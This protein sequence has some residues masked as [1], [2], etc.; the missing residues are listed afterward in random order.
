MNPV[1]ASYQKCCT[2][3]VSLWLSCLI[4]VGLSARADE[5]DTLRQKW[6]DV[7]VG[8]GYNTAD[9]AV[10]SKLTSVSN[11]A[12]SSWSSM[13]K[14]GSR[15]YL[16]SDAASTTVSADL[17]T[18]YSRLRNMALAYATP[19]CTLQGNSALLADTLSGLDWMHT[20]RYNPTKAIYDNWWDFEIGSPLQIVDIATLLYNQ[21]S[22]SQMSNY[23]ASVEKFTPSATTQAPGGT[24]G[25]FTGAN[26]M[27]KIRVVAV[28]GAVM[29]SS[30]KLAA[31]RD[32]FSE[33]FVYATSGDGFYT[34]GS[35]LQHTIHPYTAGYGNSLLSNIAPVMNWLAGSTW[36]VTDPSQA[37]L[38]RWVFDSYEPIIYRGASLDYVRGRE[39]GRSGAS[40][41]ATGHAMLDSVLQ[42]AQ[43]APP[44]DAARMKS[45]VKEW[46]LS[47]TVRD[48]VGGRPLPTLKM[49][50]DLMS[51]TN[52]VRRGELIAHYT[53]PEM[54]RVMHLGSGY[55]FG[56]SLCSTRIANF[57][58]INGENLQGWFTGDGMTILYNS[59]LNQYGDNYWP[60]IDPY[61]LPGVT[62]DVTKSK[63]PHQ[64]A[65]IGP[66]AQGQSTLSPYNW[67]GGA[68]LGRYGAAGMQFKGVG[69]TLTGKKS[70]FMFDD[71]IVCLGSGI[72]STDSRQ[73]ET[74][75][76]NRKLSSS[77]ANRFTV[78]DTLQSSSLGWTNTLPST[79][80]AHLG[81]YVGGDDIGYYFPQPVSLTATRHARTGAIADMDY[82][83]STNAI[84]RNYLRMTLSHGSNPTDATYQYV[85]LPGRSARNT[86]TYAD[87]PQVTVLANDANVQAVAETTLGITAANFWNDSTR[88]AGIITVNKKC[89]ILVQE[90]GAF[91]DVSISDPTQTNTT[92][93][94]V[95]IARTGSLVSADSAISVTQTSPSIVMNV[96]MNGSNG[97]TFK[98]RF[99]RGTPQTL[100]LPA[101]ADTYT[102]DATAS[103]DSNFGTATSLIVKKS[104]AGFNREAYLRFTVPSYS[105]ILMGASL[106]LYPLSVSTPGVHGVCLT[107]NNSWS[108][109]AVTWNNAPT[110]SATVLASWTPNTN[111]T[112]NADVS[113]AVT[114]AGPI[115]FKV[116]ATTQTSDG[117]VTY[118]SREN[119]T[120]AYRPQLLLSIGHIPPEISIASPANGEYR[121]QAGN[122]PITVNTTVTDGAVS[123]VEFYSGTTLLGSNTTA[124][125]TFTA[126]LAGGHHQLIAVARDV[127]GLSR[128]SLV[129]HIDV[130]YAPSASALN[131]N[132]LKNASVDINLRLL[133]GD[134]ETPLNLLRF[135]VGSAQN[136]SVTLLSDGYT[137][138]FTPTTNYNGPAQFTYTVTDKSYDTRL[139]THYDFAADNLA[140]ASGQFRDAIA[141]ITLT[142]AMSYNSDVPANF[143]PQGGR[144]LYLTE[145]GTN[146][147]ARIDRSFT[148]NEIDF[149]NAN[150][151]ITGWFKRAAATN[152]DAIV[153]LGESGGFASSAM[154]LAYYSSSTTL[155]LRNYNGSTQDV[156]ISRA[157]VTTG[158]WHHFTIIRNGTTLSLY[159]DGTLA[160]SDSDFTFSF[161]NSKPLHFGG[162]TTTTGF[163]DRWWQGGLADLALFNT[164]FT[165]SEV[166]QVY[167]R[168]IA[169][170]AGQN[171]TNNIN[172]TIL[173]PLESW[174][175]Q[176]FGNATINDTADDD[177]D[178]LTNLQEYIL[179]TN[180]LV[181]DASR[182]V[183]NISGGMI[184]FNFLANQANGTGYLGLKRRYDLECSTNL[185]D[186]NSW[187]SVPGY[188]NIMGTNQTV[189]ITLPTDGT[190]RFYRLKVSLG[191]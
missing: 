98:A 140:D 153:Q 8:S 186:L 1:R 77:G 76:E 10:I 74:T 62:A 137:A 122:L 91:I 22:P 5:Y 189:T 23:M 65:S 55:G 17:T 15:T 155:N 145:N 152:M 69:V 100:P 4:L 47:D 94:N 108:E 11:S 160:G 88:T 70:W 169:Y 32:A 90:D 143:S 56:L 81:G 119:A 139:L 147:G 84:T 103:K 71:E 28:R 142:G 12:Y 92:T 150:W 163:S 171:A 125:Y 170:F 118:A 57:E 3:F 59:D 183:P 174:R 182:I 175:L 135:N 20:N 26:R 21:L 116:Y 107:T 113:A 60:T 2:R 112:V 73:I 39:I 79:T 66:R 40:P 85:I 68:T 144:S 82:G 89:S 50:Q 129:H 121:P 24:T 154:T 7:I 75:V 93:I 97:R 177:G 128:T 110:N 14:S 148:T 46:A 126:N 102:Y 151:T 35:F 61:R 149:K 111:V 173:S 51:D 161:D 157:N 132:T 48:F 101:D 30:T 31:A 120:T 104:G 37:N 27:W 45:L 95:Q 146:G 133:S 114:N 165:A 34:D 78:N 6:F 29:K 185:F 19:G 18:C 67:V 131:T 138:R 179:G 63:L 141:N 38:Y 178:G 80:W 168:P 44:A 96:N 33:L 41:Q 187:V 190:I 124:P 158:V 109:T 117:F 164:A 86:K 191:E 166:T 181:K 54:D 42:I 159:L 83:A 53:F 115:S 72:T 123:S 130:A 106:K 99:Y 36:A 180:P 105:G 9:P 167:T 188:T 87:Q 127:N 58:S 156:D 43:F 176:N 172:L 25:T 52:I 49:A 64:S 13:D 16:W 184:N 136:G 134:V 162:V